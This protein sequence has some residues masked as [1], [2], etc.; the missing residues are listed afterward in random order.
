MSVSVSVC[1][2]FLFFFVH[3]HLGGAI[4][5]VAALVLAVLPDAVVVG[6]T[7]VAGHLGDIDGD[8]RLLVIGREGEGR[9]QGGVGNAQTVVVSG[10]AVLAAGPLGE[11]ELARLVPVHGLADLAAVVGVVEP[12][13]RLL[14]VNRVAVQVLDA[15]A[16]LGVDGEVG[17][18]DFVLAELELA[19]LLL[20]VVLSGEVV[21][22]SVEA[23]TLGVLPGESVALACGRPSF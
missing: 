7:D 15:E 18:A 9:G 23:E 1:F 14:A 19:E 8:A 21:T 11:G 2:L 22:L 16:V 6:V 4:H 12:Q 5:R 10:Q 17:R 13:P 3:L 20:E